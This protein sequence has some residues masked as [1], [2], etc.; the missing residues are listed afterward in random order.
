MPA[1]VLDTL[2]SSVFTAIVLTLAAEATGTEAV[3]VPFPLLCP[4]EPLVY[5]GVSGTIGGM[6]FVKEVVGVA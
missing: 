6:L 1:P 4:F 5:K 3:A 2:A